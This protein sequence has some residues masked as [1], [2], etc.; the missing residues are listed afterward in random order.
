MAII[1]ATLANLANQ[2]SNISMFYQS[3]DQWVNFGFFVLKEIT[4]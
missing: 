4:K 2:E 3:K 1:K